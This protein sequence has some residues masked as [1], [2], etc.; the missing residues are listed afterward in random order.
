MTKTATKK[1]RSS[2]KQ[3]TVKQ[4]TVW[5]GTV[6]VPMTD[7]LSVEARHLEEEHLSFRAGIQDFEFLWPT[8]RM[9][10]APYKQNRNQFFRMAPEVANDCERHDSQLESLRL[11]CIGAFDST[12]RSKE[13]SKLVSDIEPYNRGFVAEHLVNGATELPENSVLRDFWKEKRD[14]LFALR[15]SRTLKEILLSVED[16]EATLLKTVTVLN[17]RLQRRQLDLADA[18]GLPAVDPEFRGLV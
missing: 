1:R 17:A 6:I 13:F 10:G 3:A 16:A 11:A 18:F 9:I 5:L 2:K 4:V 14:S 12:M 8:E 15:E 7:A